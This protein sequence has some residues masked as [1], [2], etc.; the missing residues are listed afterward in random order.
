MIT[1]L[2]AA[3]GEVTQREVDEVWDNL[4]YR[5]GSSQRIAEELLSQIENFKPIDSTNQGSQLQKLHDLCK[6]VLYNQTRCP[7]L[8]IMDLCTGLKAVR[9]KLP[10]YIQREWAK[11]GHSYEESNSGT[12]P[13]FNVFVEFIR[14]QARQK[15]NRSYETITNRA[16]TKR[17]FKVLS[18]KIKEDN[19]QNVSQRVMKLHCLKKT[20]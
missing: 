18:T 12:H 8:K 19:F 9:A 5:Y 6:V 3:T 2:L 11:V 7:E 20:S 15:S 1:Q 10:E 4:I 17:I 14:N 13:P 16:T